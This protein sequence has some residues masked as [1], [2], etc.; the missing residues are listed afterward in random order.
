MMAGPGGAPV[1][2]SGV[3]PPSAAEAGELGLRF[4]AEAQ[5][6]LAGLPP[7]GTD[8]EV[9]RD[10]WGPV[11]GRAGL[12]AARALVERG[13][14]LTDPAAV[15][16]ASAETLLSA[17]AAARAAGAGVFAHRAFRRADADDA[18]PRIGLYA[19]IEGAAVETALVRRRRYINFSEDYRND[20]TAIVDPENGRAFRDYDFDALIGSTHVYRGWVELWNGPLIRLS[21]P[22]QIQNA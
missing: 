8:A 19:I 15:D 11:A 22:F 21:T 7:L 3:L 4:D 1:R 12:K 6:F 17:E 18:W 14:A 9:S 16:A 10:R 2:L 5:R 13:L 20:F